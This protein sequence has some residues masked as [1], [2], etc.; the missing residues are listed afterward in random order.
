M[1][2]ECCDN[3]EYI[4]RNNGCCQRYKLCAAWLR[5][6][7][8]YWWELCE[9]VKQDLRR[10]KSNAKENQEDIPHQQRQR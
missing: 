4:A 8:G 7:R 5:W 10:R 9:R 6:F 1:M 3:C 2:P